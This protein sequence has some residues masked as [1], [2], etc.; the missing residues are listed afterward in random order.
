MNIDFAAPGW[1]VFSTTINSGYTFDSGTSYAT[2]LFCGVVAVLFS[3]NP[4]LRPE[5]VINLLKSTA[6]D[7]GPSGWDMW[8][9]WGRIDFGAAAAAASATLPVLS[10]TLQTDGQF[11]VATSFKSGLD[12]TCGGPQDCPALSGHKFPTRY[13]PQTMSRFS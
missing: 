3:I 5:E 10:G 6:A 13:C 12:Y 11:C 7:K 8:Y 1:Q 9:G 2:P 4:T